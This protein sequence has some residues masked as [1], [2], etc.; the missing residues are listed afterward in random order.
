MAYTL[1]DCRT[2][3]VFGAAVYASSK[4]ELISAFTDSALRAVRATKN[5][6][7]GFVFTGQGAQW[8]A[9]GREL[10][11]R[12]PVFSQSI[13]AAG[14]HLRHMGADWDLRDEL[15][16]DVTST[17]V[18]EAEISQP[19]CTALQV[20][21]IDLLAS[22]DIRPAAVTGHSSGEIAA[23]YCAG[24]LSI[25]D[26]ISVS[27]HRGLVSKL[28]KKRS[29]VPGAMMAINMSEVEATYLLE[30]LK[31]G[32]VGVACINS[33][34][35]L[36][37]SG[38]E[39]GVDELKEILDGMNIF[40][41]KLA[42]DV[43]YH[44]NHMASVTED[45]L[46]AI[47]SVKPL[48]EANPDCI[49]YSSVTGHQEPFQKLGPQYWVNNMLGKVRFECALREMCERPIPG[50]GAKSRKSNAAKR[51]I[52]ALCEVGPHSALAGPARQILSASAQLRD[53]GIAV[54]SFLV[55]KKD[56]ERT[57]AD[58]LCKLRVM[59][60]PVNIAAFNTA[61]LTPEL[62]K[63]KVL[64]DLP[65]YPWSHAESYWAESRLSKERRLTPYGRSDLLGV[66]V[67]HFNPSEPRW[68]NII[69][70]GEMPWVKDHRVQGSVVYPAAGFVAMALEATAL[71][72]RER[73]VQVTA[74]ELREVTIGQ[75]L[76]I[77]DD[78]GEVEVII[79]VRPFSDSVRAP[80][81]SWN[82]FS[83][84]S[85]SPENRWTEHSRGL[86]RA[87]ATSKHDS[88][89]TPTQL[90]SE[91]SKVAEFTQ[92]VE[93]KATWSISPEEFYEKLSKLGLDYGP[94]FANAKS[95]RGGPN[96]AVSSIQ[97]ADTASVMP[98]NFEYPFFLHPSTLDSLFHPLFAAL[99]LAGSGTELQ[100]PLVP[101]SINRLL[102]SARM[103]KQPGVQLSTWTEAKRFDDRQISASTVVFDSELSSEEAVLQIE[104]LNCTKIAREDDATQQGLSR[105]ATF[106]YKTTWLP[107]VDELSSSDFTLICDG[108][109]PETREESAIE[110]FE[111][112]GYFLMKRAFGEVTDADVERALPHHKRLY[113]CMRARLTEHDGQYAA[114]D[115]A[116]ESLLHEVRSLSAEGDLLVHVG[117]K[118]V[119]IIRQSRD[120]LELM[121][122]GG[123]LDAFY[124]DNWRFDRNYKQAKMYLNLAAHKNPN[125]SMLEIGSGTG[126]ATLPVLQAL[127]DSVTGLCR[128]DRFVFTDISTGFFEVA[129]KKLAQWSNLV[130]YAK[131]DIEA[132]PTEQGFEE[133][134]YDVILAANVLHATRS[135]KN[136]MANVRKLLKP[137]GKL[138]LVELTRER[139]TTSTIFGTLPGWFAGEE[140]DRL[141][142]PTLTENKWDILLR[143]T[144]FDGLDVVASDAR[145]EAYHQGSMMVATA[146]EPVVSGQGITRVAA[147]AAD[148]LIIHEDSAP[149]SISVEEIRHW[150]QS[151]GAQA[152]TT[153]NLASCQPKGKACI[154]L[155][156]L[157]IPLFQHPTDAIFEKLK[158]IFTTAASVLWITK[159]ALI[160]PTDPTSNMVT[161]FA[162]AV[163][164][165]YGHN[166]VVT[167]D[168]DSAPAT[169]AKS[170]QAIQSLTSRHLLQR[171][172]VASTE[173]EYVERAGQLLIPRL[174]PHEDLQKSMRALLDPST[175]EMVP[176]D[177]PDRP[178][179]VNV[180]TPGLIDTIVFV[181]DKRVEPDLPTDAVEISVKASG[182]IFK[183]IMM[184]MGQIAVETLGGECS[185]VIRRVGTSVK[186]LAV[187]DRVSC[188]GLGTFA[189]LVRQDAAAVQ[190]IPDDM[191]FELAAALP[192]NF[193]TAYYSVVHIARV[194]RSQTVLIHAA[195]G[196]LGQALIEMCKMLDAEIFC[197]VGTVEKKQLLMDKYGISEDHILTSRDAHFAPAIMRMTNGK[198]VDVIMNSVAGEMLRLTWNCIA[199]FGVFIE[200]GARDY[201][202]N[203]RLEM[204]KFAQ[205]VTF[206][207]VNLA[208]LMRER[209]AVAAQVWSE[210]MKL[211]HE[212]KLRGPTPLTT[213]SISQLEP[214]LRLMQSGKHV[215][216]LV[217][218]H[219]Q[220]DMVKATPHIAA[221]KMT[222]FKADASYLLVG[223]MGGLGRAMALWM[224]SHGARN[225]I[226]ASRSGLDRVEARELEAILESSGANVVVGKC[227]VS[228]MADLEGLM[229]Q[230][231][232]LPPV[233]G[234]IQG[235]MVLQD[236][237]LSNMQVS[238]YAAV[239]KPKVDGTWNLHHLFEST[240]LDFFVMLS[241]TAGV[242]GNASQAAYAASSTFL[243]SFALYRRAQGLAAS[244]I[245]LGVI[246]GIG[247]VA[248]N[249]E[250]AQALE[251]QGFEGTDEEHFMTLLHSAVLASPPVHDVA[252]GHMVT[253]MGTWN[254]SSLNAFD[255]PIFSHFRQLSRMASEAAE[256]AGA[257]TD[258]K[259]GPVLSV[260]SLLKSARK[261]DE[262]EKVVCEGL[263]A[264]VSSLAMIPVEDISTDRP[265][266]EYGMDSLVAV[267][268]RNWIARE[269]D[270]AVP[271]LELMANEPIHK[272]AAK[273]LLKSR[274]VDVA[275][276]TS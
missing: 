123:R 42:V 252:L 8:W 248:Q 4:E 127:T 55:R 150:L 75:A 155:S 27:Y 247:Y 108:L 238:D 97:I 194:Q 76:V 133:G 5:G 212:K 90:D 45:Y 50:L 95:L 148:L 178:L 263:V 44:S 112:A 138:V 257:G 23:A 184:A 111:K 96:T 258:P 183:D 264:K 64:S 46:K 145:S 262:A 20:A 68:R 25:E 170:M 128:L 172:P 18:N 120:A 196:G 167:L 227:D 191:S 198:G 169:A 61:S 41:R 268:M 207:S 249:E 142:G 274:L 171:D 135:M 19:V 77:P 163:N 151:K 129:K 266:A 125:M 22:F 147:P 43:A 224:L 181:D 229:S 275:K 119:P 218:V 80:S 94:M 32:K 116:V 228:K 245:D 173:H 2:K 143:E 98:N 139:F 242:I 166:I 159:G 186:D 265:L 56:A 236:C 270:A 13:S 51:I 58:T 246:K 205:N 188:Y 241:S 103:R 176:F 31:E 136:T 235:A 232:H 161:G 149:A 83:I 21:L 101:V 190:K 243:D 82:E 36:T 26:A 216:K 177:Q 102:L 237:F 62:R 33:P 261:R 89:S 168:L 175:Y 14:V 137:G 130:S 165:E 9:M 213:Y 202:I 10:F 35:S 74:F 179:V 144:G 199:P 226:F 3:F 7:L 222:L 84:S 117:Q 53:R 92:S 260:R 272:L 140:E 174:T 210:A 71:Q 17:R 255:R 104:G 141:R 164:S 52:T 276:L 107:D 29:P 189:S 121:I 240:P 162:R 73:S 180:G 105:K 230:C 12:F 259:I 209:P 187:G 206:A 78:R 113:N 118:L 93:D 132:D 114:E 267:E 146:C 154:V 57:M 106:G 244:T 223:G 28:A 63:P 234:V 34:G 59:G 109:V 99:G 160:S 214:A 269:I 220:G 271:V 131:L 193:C 100:D 157:S 153:A 67:P 215:G 81:D 204:A 239:V 47:S 201:T 65:P 221:S 225:F 110:S 156:E 24:A 86:V 197:T 219:G 1:S 91:K 72:A 200:L 49:F 48:A 115:S 38:D 79:S 69:R 158:T 195:S 233:K 54:L 11:T 85:V 6:A 253:G 126:G 211:F 254:E 30:Q 192:V 182:M 134:A 273:V 217:V 231:E 185:G 87:I 152:V 88:V 66:P 203:T 70:T 208:H 16:R 60:F 124:R 256:G 122:E 37:V 251:C 40:A 15:F 39:S 250:L